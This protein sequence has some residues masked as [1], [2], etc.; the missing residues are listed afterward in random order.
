MVKFIDFF[1]DYLFCFFEFKEVKF[2]IFILF[3]IMYNNAFVLWFV[4]CLFRK[5][6]VYE[7]RLFVC[8]VYRYSRII[9]IIFIVRCLV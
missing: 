5:C 4:F 7:G 6:D 1:L 8:F 2:V 3:S 9:G